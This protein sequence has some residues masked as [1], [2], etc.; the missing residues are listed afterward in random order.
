MD[1]QNPEFVVKFHFIMTDFIVLNVFVYA[2]VIKKI[3]R[4]LVFNMLIRF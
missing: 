2:F 4:A 3:R 1:K